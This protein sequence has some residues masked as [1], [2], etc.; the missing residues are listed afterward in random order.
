MNRNYFILTAIMLILALGTLFL[1]EK[2]VSPQI[3]PGELLWDILQPT[4]Y[5]TT[6]QVAQRLIENDPSLL[7]VDVRPA[8]EFNKFSLPT[9]VNVPMDSLLTSSGQEYFGNPGIRV[10]LFAN[11]DILSDQAWVLLRRLAYKNNYVMTGGLNGWIETIIRPKEPPQT[12]PETAFEQ[13]EFRKAARMYFTGAKVTGP[14]QSTTK[15]KVVFKKRKRAAVAAGG[16]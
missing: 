10:V 3:Q 2:T 14:G 11:D 4:R 1:H 15:T 12:A 5:V 16:C 6:D 8:A 7:L 13:Y 9:A